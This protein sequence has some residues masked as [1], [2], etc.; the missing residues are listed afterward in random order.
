M[1]SRIFLHPDGYIEIVFAGIQQTEEI[2]DLVQQATKLFT[3]HG[4]MSVLIDGRF[5]R[6]AR[7]ASTFSSLMSIARDTRLKE[8]I[9][10]IDTNT[11]NPEA[12]HGPSVVTNILTSVFGR[13]PVYIDDEAE[14]RARACGKQGAISR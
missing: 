6:I 3:Q 1:G 2:R 4:S 14:A 13:R 9:I 5:G 11:S 10:L 12:I 8:M 7:D